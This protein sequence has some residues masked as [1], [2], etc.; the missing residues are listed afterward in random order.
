[1]LSESATKDRLATAA[2]P[3]LIAQYRQLLDQQ[4]KIYK[5]AQE[6]YSQFERMS[7]DQYAL[8]EQSTQNF[9]SQVDRALI[10]IRQESQ[11]S[12]TQMQNMMK[13]Q[14]AN[15]VAMQ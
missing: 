6:D 7:Y 9:A 10:A 3:G 12:F 11:E 15:V 13:P 4:H 5:Q 8:L 2:F 14:I 1:L